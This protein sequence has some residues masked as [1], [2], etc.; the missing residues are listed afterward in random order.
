MKF[1]DDNYNID[2]LTF[3]DEKFFI[4]QK[5]WDKTYTK[6]MDP[7]RNYLKANKEELLKRMNSNLV[8]ELGEKICGRRS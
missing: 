2:T 6:G 3:E 1:Y 8:D 7:M 5:V 4:E